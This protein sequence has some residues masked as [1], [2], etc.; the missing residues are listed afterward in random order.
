MQILLVSLRETE[1]HGLRLLKTV[2]SMSIQYQTV[3][4][5]AHIKEP[6]GS[7]LS[8]RRGITNGKIQ[9]LYSSGQNLFASERLEWLLNNKFSAPCTKIRFGIAPGNGLYGI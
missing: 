4:L 3:W 1:G 5:C 8:D 6:V 9:W 2:T 7:L